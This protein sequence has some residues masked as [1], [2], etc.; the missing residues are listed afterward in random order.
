MQKVNQT[1]LHNPP[2]Q[3]GNC[4]RAVISSLTDIPIDEIIPI[5]DLYDDVNWQTRMICF[6]K[7][8]GWIWRSAPEFK[9]YYGE[10]KTVPEMNTDSMKDV[11]YAVVGKTNRF[12]GQVDHICI[13]MNGELWHDP[14]P[15][16]TGLITMDSFEIFE[17]INN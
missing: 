4:F 10:G 13:Y 6:L 8:R 17:R 2:E 5:E 11:A 16:N 12:S 14:H 3:N 15:E 1:K 7:N 9:L